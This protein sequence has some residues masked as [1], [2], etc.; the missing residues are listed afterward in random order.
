MGLLLL[1]ILG[2]Q[3]HTT[4]ESK[5]SDKDIQTIAKNNLRVTPENYVRAESDF[6]FKSYVE[7]LDC[8]GKLVHSREAYDVNNQI[9]VRGNRDTYYSFGVF[10]L[11]SPLTITMP[12]PSGRYQSIMAV[13]QD[14]SIGSMYGPNERRKGKTKHSFYCCG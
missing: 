14:H 10:D 9:T 1:G 11:N 12:E 5:L 6:Q 7:K 2:C 4:K 3:E 13:S 8:F